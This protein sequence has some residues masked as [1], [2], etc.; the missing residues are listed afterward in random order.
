MFNIG[1]PFGFNNQFYNSNSNYFINEN[2]AVSAR[3]T[4]TRTPVQQQINNDA[5][6]RPLPVSASK[7]QR[8]KK[9][10]LNEAPITWSTNQQ[11][12]KDP[13]LR[14]L[15]QEPMKNVIGKMDTTKTGL[16]LL[17]EKI[18]EAAST[19][20][21]ATSYTPHLVSSFVKPSFDNGSSEGELKYTTAT[22]QLVDTDL[23][24]ANDD[25]LNNF[26][27]QETFF[28][29]GSIDFTDCLLDIDFQLI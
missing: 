29:F 25:L 13:E 19:Q 15:L 27:I 23:A 8:N 18:D 2:L 12:N 28:D 16:F 14:K 22:C 5:F 26:N 3:T 9:R 4:T 20:T 10:K 17:F 24:K 1:A 6:K 11:Q 7:P 21:S